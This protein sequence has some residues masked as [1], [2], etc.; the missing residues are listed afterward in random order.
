MEGGGD[1]K[2]LNFRYSGSAGA[3]AGPRVIRCRLPYLPYWF[4][5]LPSA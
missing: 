4:F 3:G 1:G 2:G 5:I